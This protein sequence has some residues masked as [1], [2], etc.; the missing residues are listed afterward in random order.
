M[1]FIRERDAL[2]KEGMTPDTQRRL[3]EICMKLMYEAKNPICLICNHNDA[4]IHS[5]GCCKIGM[6]CSLCA[7]ENCN[8]VRCACGSVTDN[9]WFSY[10]TVY[11]YDAMEIA[12]GSMTSGVVCSLFTATQYWECV[13]ITIWLDCFIRLFGFRGS[14]GSLVGAG[15]LVWFL[16]GTFG[17]FGVFFI[18]TMMVALTMRDVRIKSAR[19]FLL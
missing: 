10:D 12:I 11:R 1:N 18:T 16:N 3:R 8:K 14:H 6:I 13:A 5:L 4:P 9:W 17:Y 15:I 7:S 2:L 19:Q